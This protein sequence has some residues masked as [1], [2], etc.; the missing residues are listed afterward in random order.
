[1]WYFSYLNIKGDTAAEWASVN[2]GIFLCMNCAAVHRNFGIHVSF[3]RSMTMDAWNE[4]QLKCMTNGGNKNIRDLFDTYELHNIP[5]EERY[6]TN[7]AEWN[8][9]C[10]SLIHQ[11]IS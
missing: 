11:T 10:V 8:R 7:I 1:L 3:V 6:E 4:K 2:N 5:I 9:Q